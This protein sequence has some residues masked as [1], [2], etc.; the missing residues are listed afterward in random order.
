[1]ADKSL[2]LQALGADLQKTTLLSLG[3]LSATDNDVMNLNILSRD[4]R[5]DKNIYI[6]I[7]TYIEE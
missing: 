7:Y 5:P 1:M 2:D 3:L 6:S 4:P